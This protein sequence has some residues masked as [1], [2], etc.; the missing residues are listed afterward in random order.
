MYV[1]VCSRTFSTELEYLHGMGACP[2]C[3]KIEHIAVERQLR[4]TFVPVR[5]GVGR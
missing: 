4:N 2:L 1:Y 5:S 3:E